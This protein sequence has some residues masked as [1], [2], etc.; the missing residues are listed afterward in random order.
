MSLGKLLS[1]AE[2][3]RDSRQIE[4]LTEAGIPVVWDSGAFSVFTGRAEITVDEHARWVVDSQDRLPGNRFLALDVIGDPVATLENYRTSIELGARV[5]PTIHFGTSIAQIERLLDVAVPEWVNVGGLVGQRND[6]MSAAM[7]AAVRRELPD[8]VKVHA[9]GC[10]R[11]QVSALVPFEGCDS[12][13]WLTW[14]QYH[15]ISLWNPQRDRFD[16]MGARSER[17]W[18]R[19]F[20]AGGWL[21]SEYGLEPQFLQDKIDR[22]SYRKGNRAGIEALRRFSEWATRLHGVE[23]ICY[24]AGDCGG[25]SFG[26]GSEYL[27][28]NYSTPQ[29]QETL[30]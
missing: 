13:T 17:D 2:M 21:R 29:P 12:S 8:G 3:G 11:T 20:E 10:T 15:Q 30:P 28:A 18:R 26:L 5:E 24:L 19:T 27:V 22:D 7:I 25:D 6:R 14:G 4:A 23:M 16:V 9:L 1:Y